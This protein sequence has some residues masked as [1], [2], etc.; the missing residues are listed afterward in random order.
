MNL[1]DV[2]KYKQRIEEQY[3]RSL[4]LLE[5]ERERNIRLC[6]E[7]FA[8]AQQL[9][10]TGQAETSPNNPLESSENA[11]ATNS[12]YVQEQTIPKTNQQPNSFREA[13]RAVFRDL[14]ETYTRHDLTTAIADKFPE[15]H[16][17]QTRDSVNGA[18]KEFLEKGLAKIEVEA[19]STNPTVYRKTQQ[20]E[21]GLSQEKQSLFGKVEDEDLV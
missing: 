16:E 2:L 21:N 19:H 17:K 14:P 4:Q 7:F 18:V 8:L 12:N 10:D 3:K 11:A 20:V 6:D 15:W 13:A 9:D 5:A 1:D